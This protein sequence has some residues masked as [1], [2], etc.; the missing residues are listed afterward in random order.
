MILR[1]A[2]KKVIFPGWDPFEVPK[3]NPF[4]NPDGSYT[5]PTRNPFLNADGTYTKP[6]VNPFLKRK[7][8]KK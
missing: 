4:L 1:H 6:T 3:K 8:G 7:T 2:G 5:K